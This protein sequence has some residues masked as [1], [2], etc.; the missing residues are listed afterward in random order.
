MGFV[1]LLPLQRRDGYNVQG[2]HGGL[3]GR[4]IQGIHLDRTACLEMGF[5]TVANGNGLPTTRHQG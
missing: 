1:N 2:T 5:G 3:V 4:G